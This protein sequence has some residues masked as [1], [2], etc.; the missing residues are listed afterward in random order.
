MSGVR[1]KAFLFNHGKTVR[2][3][4]PKRIWEAMGAPKEFILR[5][6]GNRIVLEPVKNS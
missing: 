1:V 3:T 5:I 2:I 4:I 6:D